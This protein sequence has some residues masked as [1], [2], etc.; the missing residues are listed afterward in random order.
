MPKAAVASPAL[1]QSI[2]S[3]PKHQSRL[4]QHTL[5][6]YQLRGS[7]VWVQYANDV[8]A[9]VPA[10]SCGT[11]GRSCLGIHGS[12]PA[13][14]N[15]CR[16]NRSLSGHIAAGAAPQK[17]RGSAQLL[18]AREIFARGECPVSLLPVKDMQDLVRTLLTPQIP[19]GSPAMA[20]PEAACCSMHLLLRHCSRMYQYNECR[21]RRS[22]VYRTVQTTAGRSGPAEI[23]RL[24]LLTSKHMLNRVRLGVSSTCVSVWQ[25]HKEGG[26]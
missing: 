4:L 12:W 25:E 6:Q 21:Q 22:S 15:S 3:L 1:C 17:T 24:G 19:R 16:I 13:Y 9:A 11:G 2:T 7:P 26:P 14:S 8:W 20:V 10:G 5:P 18:R 23:I